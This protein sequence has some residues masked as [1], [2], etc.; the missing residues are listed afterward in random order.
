MTRYIVHT[1]PGSPFARAVMAMLEEKDATWTLAPMGPGELR[2]EAHLARHPLGK[3]PALEWDGRHLYET[4]AILRYLDDTIEGASLVPA[5]VDD[6]ARMNQVIGICECYLFPECVR[7]VAFQRVVGP[8]IVPGFETDESAIAAAMPRSIE[9]VGELSR[10][11]GER[12]WF[13][14]EHL[15]LADLMIGP[16]LEFL[17]RTPEWSQLTLGRENLVFWLA[18]MEARPSMQVTL[19]ERLPDKITAQAA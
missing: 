19:W 10:L 12:E 4:Q 3:M 7:I 2:S 5:G 6:R 9:I 1:V 8:A 15:S 13:G 14:G 18:R 16:Q 17:S 11:L